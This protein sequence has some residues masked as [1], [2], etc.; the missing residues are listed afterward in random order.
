M[1]IVKEFT[2]D[3][4]HNLINYKGKCADLHG[5]TYKLQVFISGPVKKNGLVWDFA[6]LKSIVNDK[7]I[8]FVDHKYLNDFIKQPSAE[9]IAIWIWKQLKKHMP[10]YEVRLWESPTN[11]VIYHGKKRRTR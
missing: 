2:F 7:V 11:F 1:I 4:A 8:S 6:D 9:N 5:H 10:L 3:A